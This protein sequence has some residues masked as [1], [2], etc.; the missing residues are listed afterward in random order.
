MKDTMYYASCKLLDL[1]TMSLC[2]LNIVP[3]MLR[4][5]LGICGGGRQS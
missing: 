3:N 2:Y 4:Y 1:G 5:T